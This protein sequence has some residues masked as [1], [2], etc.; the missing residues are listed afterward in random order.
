MSIFE[1]LENG[2]VSDSPE[3]TSALGKELGAVFPTECILA[4]RGDLG[5]GK[6]TF[7]KGFG[8]ALGMDPTVIKSPSFNIYHI[9]EGS[10]K[11]IHMDLYRLKTAHEVDALMIEEW[12]DAPWIV[13]VEWPERGLPEWMIEFTWW[14]DFRVVDQGLVRLELKAPYDR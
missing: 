12:L 7:T 13:V 10:V 8:T 4:L 6:T 11:L 2:I 14:L 9:H 5:A 3:M 1:R